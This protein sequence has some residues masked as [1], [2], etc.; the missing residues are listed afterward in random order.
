MVNS[1]NKL[2]P[3]QVGPHGIINMALTPRATRIGQLDKLR[4]QKSASRARRDGGKSGLGT[5]E[6]ISNL[7]QRR[8]GAEIPN[9]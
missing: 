6:K 7:A 2:V 5:C 9:E 8:K 4:T 1:S 3:D